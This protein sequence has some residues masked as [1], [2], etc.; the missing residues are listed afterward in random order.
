MAE[1]VQTVKHPG[2]CPQDED[3]DDAEKLEETEKF[4]VE[5]PLLNSADP[6]YFKSPGR[7]TPVTDIKGNS[8][9]MSSRKSGRSSLMGS[10]FIPRT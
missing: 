9:R 7:L 5:S 3:H 8:P 6:K 10:V 4:P 2:T 1:V